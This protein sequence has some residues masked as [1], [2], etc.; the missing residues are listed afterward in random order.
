MT[1]AHAIGSSDQQEEFSMN[2]TTST[3][4]FTVGSA[5]G[6]GT[7]SADLHPAIQPGKRL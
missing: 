5:S 6:I 7:K 3:G 2:Q 1:T 4:V